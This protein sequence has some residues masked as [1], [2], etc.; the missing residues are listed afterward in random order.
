MTG[1]TLYNGVGHRRAGAGRCRWPAARGSVRRACPSA[2]TEGQTLRAILLPQ[3]LTAMLPAL[4][5]QLVVVLKDSALGYVITYEELLNKARPVGT[6]Q[7]N[8]VPAFLVV[9]VLFIVINYG[10]TRLAGLLERQLPAAAGPRATSPVRPARPG[11][12]R[13]T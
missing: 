6:S 1:L 11:R 9:A 12:S 7:Q 10:L 8:I 4:V 3:A 13:S 5:G 2:C